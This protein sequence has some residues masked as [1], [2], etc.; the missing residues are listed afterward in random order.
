VAITK[1]HKSGKNGS[2]KKNIFFTIIYKSCLILC[3]SLKEIGQ[4]VNEELMPQDFI[5]ELIKGP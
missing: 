4:G 5:T 2:R 1:G 3:I